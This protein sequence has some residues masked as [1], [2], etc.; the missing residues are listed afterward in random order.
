MNDVFLKVLFIGSGITVNELDKHMKKEAG[1]MNKAIN[2]S[3][4]CPECGAPEANGL[5]CRGQLEE[6]LAWE[7]YSPELAEQHFW[8][9]ACFNI[10][11]P[12]TITDDSWRGLCAVF[13]EAYDENLTVKDIRGQVSSRT[14]GAA[15]IK[16]GVA[17]KPIA[18]EWAMAISEVYLAGEPKGAADRV[19]A[20]SKVI[21]KQIEDFL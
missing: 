1:R 14:E 8:T 13:C 16:R 12:S 7:Q 3:K 19:R 4:S 10:Q 6:I 11:H 5:D 9:V 17:A 18:R 15:R 2:Y 21:R 20:W